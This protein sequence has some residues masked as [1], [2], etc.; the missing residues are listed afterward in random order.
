MTSRIPAEALIHWERRK[1]IA[2]GLTGAAAGAGGLDKSTAAIL[3]ESGAFYTVSYLLYLGPWAASS[4][5]VNASSLGIWSVEAV[6]AGPCCFPQPRESV[7][8][9]WWSPGHRVA[10]NWSKSTGDATD[11]ISAYIQSVTSR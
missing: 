7:I 11:L 1:Y 4:S 8:G 6:R 9:S 3:V 5:A 2:K 10:A